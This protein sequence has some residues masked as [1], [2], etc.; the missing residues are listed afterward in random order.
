[1]IL[2]WIKFNNAID[3]CSDPSKFLNSLK[4]QVHE[5]SITMFF[6]SVK[7]TPE[8]PQETHK[9]PPEDPEEGYVASPQDMKKENV[10]VSMEEN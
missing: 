2:T 4:K 10:I 9:M 1:M 7:K 5:I 6:Q 8:K 3:A